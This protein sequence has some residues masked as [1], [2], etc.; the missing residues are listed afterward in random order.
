MP[1][2]DDPPDLE[3]QAEWNRQINKTLYEQGL[4]NL[5]DNDDPDPKMHG[6]DT[7]TMPP[8]MPEW[9]GVDNLTPGP[10]FPL[11]RPNDHLPRPED[12]WP[13]PGGGNQPGPSLPGL[14]DQATSGPNPFDSNPY[15]ID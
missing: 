2:F 6:L 4:P 10:S 3:K 12:W 1:H 5:Y 7:S 9:A 11:P 14:I 13:E 8:P 15:F